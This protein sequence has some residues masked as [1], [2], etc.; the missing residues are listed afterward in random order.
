MMTMMMVVMK[1]MMMMT[2]R[3]LTMTMRMRMLAGT[4]T[5]VMVMMMMMMT[6][7]TTMT[8]MVIMLIM[9]MLELTLDRW[10]RSQG[11]ERMNLVGHSFGGHLTGL[12]ALKYPQHLNTATLADPWGMTVRPSDPP[13]TSTTSSS[14][15]SSSPRRVPGWVRV[16]ARVLVHFNPL[17][18]LRAAGPAGPWVVAR[19]RPDIVKKYEELLGEKNTGLVSDY[20]FHCNGHSP[21]GETAFHRLMSGFGWANSPLLPRLDKLDPAGE[22][23]TGRDHVT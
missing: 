2:M 8:T 18:G 10:R 21:A 11:L 5:V 22:M 15:T 13:S 16:L 14:N 17:W 23:L 9:T 12:Y 1:M 6:T 4:V 7:M 19:T 20:I 3:K